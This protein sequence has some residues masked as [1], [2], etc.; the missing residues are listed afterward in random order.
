MRTRHFIAALTIAALS[1][2]ARADAPATRP[3]STLDAISWAVGEWEIE[4][5]WANGNPFIA[6][7]RYV[8]GPGG[9]Y[10]MA[11]TWVGDASNK[12]GRFQRDVVIYSA[13]SGVLTQHVFPH[14]GP[15][16]VVAATPTDDGSLLF[17]WIK[18]DPA[19]GKSIPLRHR[20]ARL[21]SGDLRWQ[22]MMQIKDEWHTT[23]DGEWR[24]ADGKS[25]P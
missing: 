22:A 19:T 21:P 13:E 5:S 4:A 12:E 3:A 11:I 14:D 1:S 6:N 25:R 9:R 2:L 23:I 17:E 15:P 10:V 24:R 20:F 18:T 8:L 16:R 7:A